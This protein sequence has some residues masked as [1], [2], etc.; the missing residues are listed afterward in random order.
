MQLT[1]KYEL[2]TTKCFSQG[3]LSI[4]HLFYCEKKMN[5]IFLMI[6]QLRMQHHLIILPWDGTWRVKNIRG[7]RTITTNNKKKSSYFYF[8][9]N[10]IQFLNIFPFFCCKLFN[11]VR[12]LINFFA[13]YGFSVCNLRREGMEANVWRGNEYFFL[14]W[15]LLW[16]Y[17]LFR[18]WNAITSTAAMIN[19]NRN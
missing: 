1:F 18:W 10:V 14:L 9:S 17:F 5:K 15:T 3:I 8:F 13:F 6:V 7:R 19:I 11:R 4:F 16:F 2:C 12:N